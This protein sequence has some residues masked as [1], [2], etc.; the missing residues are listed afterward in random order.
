M[1]AIEGRHGAADAE[2]G[3][4]PPL[5]RA[6]RRRSLT[7]WINADEDAVREDPLAHG[8][9]LPHRLRM[10]GTKQKHPRTLGSRQ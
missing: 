5:V 1:E 2:F 8:S 9:S 10:N 7:F 6:E 3:P 4:H